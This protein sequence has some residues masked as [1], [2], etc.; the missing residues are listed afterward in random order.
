MLQACQ[1]F[2]L[3]ETIEFIK[4]S[5]HPFDASLLRDL[6]E[7]LGQRCSRVGHV[8]REVAL[9][10]RLEVLAQRLVNALLQPA[11][12]RVLLLLH[13]DIISQPLRSDSV[14][15]LEVAGSDVNQIGAR[16]C[17]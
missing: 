2:A 7:P 14:L 16:Q 1:I 11:N 6:S 10:C 13:V 8:F 15:D 9:R 3:F 5:F 4:S 17:I 12:T